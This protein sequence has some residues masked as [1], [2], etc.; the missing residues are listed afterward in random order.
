[1]KK[2]L[3]SALIVGL[4][5]TSSCNKDDDGGGKSCAQLLDDITAEAADYAQNQS[6]ENCRE[7][8]DAIK[9]YQNKNCGDE[10]DTILIGLDC[11]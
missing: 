1:M 10:Y 2:L 5:F 8:R 9:A 11:A 3:F 7:L 4:V 6:A